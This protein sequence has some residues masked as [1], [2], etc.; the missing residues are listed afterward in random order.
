MS[1]GLVKE[2]TDEKADVEPGPLS[3]NPPTSFMN[4]KTLKQR[5]KQKEQKEAALLRKYA[6]IEKKKT[7]D[8]Y[9]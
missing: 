3:I 7:A 4:K 2:E 8:I 5:R 6:K 9:K 1:Q